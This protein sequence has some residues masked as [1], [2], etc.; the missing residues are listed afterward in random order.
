VRDLKRLIP[1]IWPQRRKFVLSC[2]CGLMVAI[3]WGGNLTIIYPIMQVLLKE[4]TLQSHVND[5][6]AKLRETQ[7]REQGI[8]TEFQAQLDALRVAHEPEGSQRFSDAIRRLSRHQDELASAT[9]QE[10]WMLKLASLVHAS[11]FPTTEYRTFLFIVMLVVVSTFVKGVF[12]YL[13]DILVGECAETALSRVRKQLFRKMLQLDYQTISKEG[14]A[15]LMSR[16]TYDTE[17]LSYGLNIIGGRMIREPLK[18]LSCAVLAFWINWR[19][20]LLSLLVLPLIGLVFAYMGKRLKRASRRMMESMTKI[21]QILEESFDGIK[22]VIASGTAHKHRR[23]YE[24]EYGVYY[25]KAIQVVRID[26]IT[27]PTMELLGVLSLFVAL[28]PGAYLVLR[29]KTA[30]YGIQLAAEPMSVEQLAVLY[31][32]LV[33]MLDPCRRMN[34]S[35]SIL[36]RSL[37]A[38]ER[39]LETLDTKPL[40]RQIPEAVALPRHAHSI[41][42]RNLSFRYAPRGTTEQ[43]GPV[44]NGLNLKIKAGE[45]VAIVGSNGCGKSTLVQLLPRF[46]DPQAGDILIDGVSIQNARIPDLRDQIG[47]VTQETILFD[48]TLRENITYGC[49]DVDQARL[50]VAAKQAH[51]QPLLDQLPQGY[52]SPLGGQGKSLSGGQRQRVA[53]ARAILRDPAIL[54]LD[55]ATSATDAESEALIHQTLKEFVKGRT[56]L[57][58]THAMSQSL[59]DFVTRIVVMDQGQVIADGTHAQLLAVSPM[60]QRLFQAPSRR[61]AA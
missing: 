43:R 40:V 42:F 17:M 52:D 14:T 11:W 1:F 60:Y 36:R 51:L 54:I 20:T 19:L 8:I 6:I 28:L 9:K 58:I 38:F 57:L 41:E 25:S 7:R 34:A 30:I 59:L 3:L 22:V 5:E 37:T 24:D 32:L 53:L 61:E 4:K 10:W 49:R 35:I 50:D 26:S 55:E 44:L 13:Q 31:A 23:L 39:I 33:G 48:M 56:V 18:C 2:L 21:Y 12:L 27:R 15:G 47:L 45:V 46:F 29:H 16:F